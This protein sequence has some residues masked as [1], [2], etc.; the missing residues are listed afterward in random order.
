[1]STA[2]GIEIRKDSWNLSYIRKAL[3]G[4]RIEGY[5]S[6]PAQPLPFERP[7]AEE[8][9]LS[10]LKKFTLENGVKAEKIVVGL[11][12]EAVIY[13]TLK[14]PATRK[15]DIRQIL[16]FE[17]ERHLPFHPEEAY[18]DYQVLKKENTTFLILLAITKK[19]LVDA[20]YNLLEKAM[21]RPTSF[22]V[23]SFS[24]ANIL[25]YTGDIRKDSN[26][27]ILT[28]RP[29]DIEIDTLQRG[30]P[31]GSR[32]FSVD[33]Q[34]MNQAEKGLKLSTLSLDLPPLEKRLDKLIVLTPGNLK[35]K[36]DI[37]FVGKKMGIATFTGNPLLKIL[38][39]RIKPEWVNS[40][41]IA[42]CLAM[43]GI[44][45]QEIKI[46]LIPPSYRRIENRLGQTVAMILSGMIILLLAGGIL[47]SIIKE[48]IHLSKMNKQLED[49]RPAL[50][51]VYT[52]K[53]RL[54]DTEGKLKIIEGI[55]REHPSQ[56]D[57]LA[58]LATIL[59]HDTWLT[60]MEYS[61]GGIHISGFSNS[62]SGL[63]P[64]LETSR[65]FENVEFI[66]SITT[67]IE[68]KE[69]FRIKARLRGVKGDSH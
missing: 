33:G 51:E 15:R 64:I 12:R 30:I 6:I 48:M 36:N 54:E 34:E 1:M 4:A 13:R 47:S 5:T 63:L 7:E 32:D 19:T 16:P 17:I 57:L 44:E 65:H 37:E 3:T 29:T 10:E 21:L 20:I 28:V 53:K 41:F 18:Y 23:T 68:G 14:I 62:A 43:S 46:N 38:T 26:T 69:K 42:T 2:L 31:I 27:A 50:E 11:P 39:D 55:K 9:L 24:I 58:E 35:S 61:K 40:I 49:I 22:E 66:G 59:P 45:S 67:G 60:N 56:L 25:N 52:L 8:E